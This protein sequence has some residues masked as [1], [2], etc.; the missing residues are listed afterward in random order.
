MLAS[1]TWNKQKDLANQGLPASQWLTGWWTLKL[2]IQRWI[3]WTP[4]E[5]LTFAAEI[6]QLW[7]HRVQ[8]LASKTRISHSYTHMGLPHYSWNATVNS[9]SRLSDDLCDVTTASGLKFS[10]PAIRYN[11]WHFI[12][13]LYPIN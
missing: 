1:S 6:G 7:H 9:F 2:S 11:L 5:K 12:G 4:R 13:Q 3:C 8:R 10:K